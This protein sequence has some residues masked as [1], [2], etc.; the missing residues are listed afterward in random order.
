MNLTFKNRSS[1]VQA[2]D[3][4]LTHAKNNTLDFGVLLRNMSETEKAMKE[5]GGDVMK[6]FQDE[7]L[8]YVNFTSKKC[9]ICK[10]PD[11]LASRCNMRKSIHSSEGQKSNNLSETS[12]KANMARQPSSEYDNKQNNSG[13]QANSNI[14]SNEEGE[15]SPRGGYRRRGRYGWKNENLGDAVVQTSRGGGNKQQSSRSSYGSDRNN[16]I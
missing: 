12:Q 1:Y 5:L 11:H 13:N 7:Q 3:K 14:P 6:P 2:K 16:S 10:N 4:Y 9:R 8:F 15:S